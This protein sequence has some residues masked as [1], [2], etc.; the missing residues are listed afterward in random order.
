M[1]RPLHMFTRPVTVGHDRRQLLALRLRSK[2]RTLLCH[3]PIPQA[4]ASIAYPDA[5]VNHLNE[6]KQI[7]S[8]LGT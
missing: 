7:R 1:R 4:M 5:F 6:S 3:G 2:P 8:A